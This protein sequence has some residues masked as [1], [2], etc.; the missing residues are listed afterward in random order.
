MTDVAAMLDE[1]KI[2]VNNEESFAVI[3]QHGSNDIT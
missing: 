2:E 3:L 1:L